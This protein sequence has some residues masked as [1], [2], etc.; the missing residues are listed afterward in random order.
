MAGRQDIEAGRAFVS[1]YVNSSPLTKGLRAVSSHMQSFGTSIAKIGG[2]MMGA[3]GAVLTPLIGMAKGFADAGSAIADMS[4]RTGVSAENLS[5]L[6]YAAGMTGASME[7]VEKAIRKMQQHGMGANQIGAVADKLAAMTD[8]A[9]RTAYAMEVFGKS[10]AALIPMLSGGSAGLEEFRKEAERLGVIMSSKDA[11]AADALGDA[12]DK[13]KATLKGVSNQIGAALAPAVTWLAETL[14]TAATGLI[15]F[16]RHNRQIIVTVAAA[17]AG[18]AGLGT[19]LVGVGGA[20]A[21]AGVALSGIATLFGAI[22]S[23]VG[24]VVGGIVAATAAF[25]TFSD[26]GRRVAD[27]L[28]GDFGEAWQTIQ[29]TVGG[30]ADA[31]S[32]GDIGLGAEI[33]M[34]GLK[35]A[36]FAGTQ[37]IRSAWI[38]FNKSL[39]NIA[40]EAS[41]AIIKAFLWASQKVA[42]WLAE[43]GYKVNLFLSGQRDVL[44]SDERLDSMTRSLDDYYSRL[45]AGLVDTVDFMG[46]AIQD[47]LDASL[48]DGEERIAQLRAE[49]AAHRR[50]AAAKAGEARRE[51]ETAPGP[52]WAPVYGTPEKG[53]SSSAV[54]SATFSASALAA[55][56]QG[57]GPMKELVTVSKEHKRIAERHLKRM[58]ESAASLRKLEMMMTVT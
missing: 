28:R 35:A 26:T 7:D 19:A 55:M 40:V 17:A 46:G 23:P 56:G 8:P 43:I 39:V 47:T 54:S 16:V 18:I 20:V 58:D 15:Q 13:V 34:T 31:L 9:Q 38:N 14:A 24:L 3:G 36:F 53:S 48:V 32:A 30:I 50:D 27:T 51:R 22:L 44:T 41:K 5:A 57:G 2:M 33:A 29:D 6:G 37:S 42:G 45:A 52:R 1:L 10:G 12:M 49:L 11:A 25:L 21:L 4:A